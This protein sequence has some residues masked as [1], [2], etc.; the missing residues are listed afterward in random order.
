MIDLKNPIPVGSKVRV[1]P[2]NLH[3]AWEHAGKKGTILEWSPTGE[4][5][6]RTTGGSKIRVMASSIEKDR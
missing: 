4:A 1:K 5:V 2:G 3:D 6:L